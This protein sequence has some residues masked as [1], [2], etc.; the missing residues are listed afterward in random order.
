[1]RDKGFNVAD[2]RDQSQRY[3]WL[4]P[5]REIIHPSFKL[6]RRWCKGSGLED[7]RKATGADVDRACT[8]TH[9]ATAAS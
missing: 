8:K 4:P 1:M 6:W 2:N 9:R 3:C 5:R 7:T